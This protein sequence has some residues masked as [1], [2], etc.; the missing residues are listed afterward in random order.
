MRGP[1]LAVV[2]AVVALAAAA[3]GRAAD[4][5]PP[6]GIILVGPA[7]APVGLAA[8]TVEGLPAKQLSIS[9]LTEHGMRQASFAG[10]LLWTA[11]AKTGVIDPAKH[12]DQVSQF[13]VVTGSDGYRAVLAL[14]EIAPDFE[15]KQVI[16]A[17]RMD[18]KPLGPQHLRVVV[19]LDKR[20]GRSVRDVV[21]IEVLAA[22]R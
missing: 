16:L 1:N 2:L 9:F 4:V 22:P 18:G 17:D 21:R 11:L 5:S 14:A 19:P 13:I 12:R 8:A 20:G 6:A 10:P 3:P 7:H 15:A